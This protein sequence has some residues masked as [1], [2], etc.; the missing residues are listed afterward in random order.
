M[1]ATETNTRNTFRDMMNSQSVAVTLA[2]ECKN[3]KVG[4][5]PS[6]VRTAHLPALLIC[7]PGA[8]GIASSQNSVS[9]PAT[10]ASLRG[11]QNSCYRVGG[12]TWYAGALLW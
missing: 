7:R 1:T 8:R 2:V 11:F 4:T 3:K 5:T 9:Q 12:R 10:H 6:C